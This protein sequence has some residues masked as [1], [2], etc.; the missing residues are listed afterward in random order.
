M[1]KE[2]QKKM[3]D[4]FTQE[5]KNTECKEAEQPEQGLGLSIVKRIVDLMNGEITVKSEIGKGTDITVKFVFPEAARLQK[6]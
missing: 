4:P 3:F 5:N 6:T 1:S 2:F